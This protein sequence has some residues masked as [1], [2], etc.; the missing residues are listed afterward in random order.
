ML[1]SKIIIRVVHVYIDGGYS[2]SLGTGEFPKRKKSGRTMCSEPSR[3]F[4]IFSGSA[5]PGELRTKRTS[6]IFA[7][8]ENKTASSSAR[9]LRSNE[10]ARLLLFGYKL[11][12]YY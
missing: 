2:I 4:S 12:S 11:E 8:V 6:C 1:S 10:T 9:A 7:S 3:F 5:N